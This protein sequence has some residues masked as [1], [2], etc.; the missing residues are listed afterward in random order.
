MLPSVVMPT[1]F[2]LPRCTSTDRCTLHSLQGLN[3]LPPTVWAGS[4]HFSQQQ[5]PDC[6]Y[7]PCCCQLLLPLLAAR[8]VSP[9]LPG[10]IKLRILPGT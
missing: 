1:R 2:T 10:T 3:V 7:C 4:T 8:M 5:L 9:Y 6:C